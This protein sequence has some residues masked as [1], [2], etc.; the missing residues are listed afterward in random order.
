M[1][2]NQGWQLVMQYVESQI[3][4]FSTQAITEGYEEMK[5]FNL[6]RGKVEGLREMLALIDYEIEQFQTQN[7]QSTDDTTTE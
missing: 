1:Q 3:Q 4:N 6:A 5:D 2:S 7:E